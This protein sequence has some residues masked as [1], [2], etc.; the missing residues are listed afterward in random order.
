[1]EVDVCEKVASNFINANVVHFEFCERWDGTVKVAQFTQRKED[2]KFVTYSVPIDELAGTAA[3]PNEVVEGDLDISA[4]GTDPET[5]MRITSTVVTIKVERSGYVEDGETPIPPTPDLYTKFVAQIHDAAVAGAPYIADD[6]NWVIRGEN[7]GVKAD[8]SAETANAAASAESAAKSAEAAAKSAE[9]ALSVSPDVEIKTGAIVSVKDAAPVHAVELVSRIEPTQDGNGC[10]EVEVTRTGKNIITAIHAPQLPYTTDGVT[11]SDAGNGRIAV[12]G[13]AASGAMFPLNNITP[14]ER[15]YIPAGTYTIS[16][17]V[18]GT[19]AKI[20]FAAFPRQ[21]GSSIVSVTVSD[22]AKTRTITLDQDAYYGIYIA[23]SKGATSD[24]VVSPQ[25]ESGEVATGYAPY[26]HTTITADLPETVYGGS[27]NWTTGL[28]TS[29]LDADGNELAEPKT[30]QLAPKQ[31][32]MLKGANNIWSSTGDTALSYV[33][34]LKSYIDE[35]IA[36]I[37]AAVVNG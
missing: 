28:L 20:V 33:V 8:W 5:G 31:L 15:T 9:F 4:F 16:G 29:T 23:V 24:A 36:V 3:M 25:L 2:K 10:T 35:R 13:T 11:F 32:D 34:D 37:A 18:S 1:M 27:L 14:G 30:I 7:S 26:E 6:G 12:S 17:L 19:G 21:T 22:T